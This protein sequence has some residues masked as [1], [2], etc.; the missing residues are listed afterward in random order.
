M[1]CLQLQL[2]N[3]DERIANLRKSP[4]WSVIDEKQKLKQQQNYDT[5]RFVNT[6]QNQQQQ[7]LLVVNNLRRDRYDNIKK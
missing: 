4:V 2:L 5:T 7:Q 1:S 3:L 6:T